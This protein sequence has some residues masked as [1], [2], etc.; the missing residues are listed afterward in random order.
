MWHM[1]INPTGFS[2]KLNE[3]YERKKSYEQF[4]DFWPDQLDGCG[5]HLIK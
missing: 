5:F 4:Q 3:E 2:D 1:T